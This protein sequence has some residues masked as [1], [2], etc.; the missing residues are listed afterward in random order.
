MLYEKAQS[1][2]PCKTLFCMVSQFR[3]DQQ[4]C[5]QG[6]E[7]RT[8]QDLLSI[9]DQALKQGCA[10]LWNIQAIHQG[11]RKATKL[12]H[13][14]SLCAFILLVSTVTV[15]QQGCMLHAV[16]LH[17]T[18]GEVYRTQTETLA[19]KND[20]LHTHLPKKKKKERKTYFIDWPQLTNL[21]QN[22]KYLCRNFILFKH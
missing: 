11:C 13:T 12:S 8:A 9:W 10:A 5:L 2:I 6:R 16:T 17:G 14:F 3:K 15:H 1:H 21:G 19:K 18:G 22:I 7:L 20:W 4:I